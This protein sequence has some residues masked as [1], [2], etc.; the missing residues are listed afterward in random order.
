MAQITKEKI[1][2]FVKRD[3][4]YIIAIIIALGTSIYALNHTNTVADQVNTF[5]IQAFND[6]CEPYKYGM[7]SIEISND[8]HYPLFRTLNYTVTK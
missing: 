6:N 7:F 1:K 3:V 5:W 4:L 8:T 2:S